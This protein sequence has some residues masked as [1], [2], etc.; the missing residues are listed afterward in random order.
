MVSEQFERSVENF[1][2]MLGADAP[3]IHWMWN[4]K[5]QSRYSLLNRLKNR[6]A[7]ILLKF[8]MVTN[9]FL[10]KKIVFRMTIT[11]KIARFLKNL[12]YV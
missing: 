3:E 5:L 6:N 10:H 11:L 12:T 2:S 7:S 9:D 8:N 1:A 4:V